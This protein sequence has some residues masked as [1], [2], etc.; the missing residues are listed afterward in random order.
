DG[1]SSGGAFGSGNGGSSTIGSGA[2]GTPLEP[3]PS[4]E[5][6][7]PESVFHAIYPITDPSSPLAEDFS[8][9]PAACRSAT[10]YEGLIDAAAYFPDYASVGAE[11]QRMREVA[12]FLANVA[13]ETTGGWDDAP[14]G[15]EAW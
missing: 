13:K 4:L 8:I 9:C 5:E 6:L 12:A 10:I 14:G 1:A 11:E 2:G 7:L 15:K 3:H